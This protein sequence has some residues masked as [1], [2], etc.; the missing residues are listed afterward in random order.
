MEGRHLSQLLEDAAARRP[1]HPAV[2]DERGTRLNYAELLRGADRVATRL[3]RWGVGRGDRVGFWL[4]KGLEAVTAIHGI[5]RAGASYVPADPTGPPA[6]AAAILAAAGARAAIVSASMAQALRADWPSGSH[7]PRLIVVGDA[8]MPPGDADAP[9]ATWTEVM[10]DDAPSPLAPPRDDDD[11]AYILFTSGSTGQPKGVMLSHA[12]ALTFVDW[13]QQALGPW[14]VNDRFSSHAPLHFDLSIFDLFVA[15]HNAATL[16]LIGEV[17]GKDPGRLGD[18]LADRTISVWYSAPSILAMLLERG[19]LDRPGFA[20]PRVVLFAGEVFPMGSLRRLRSVWPH[21]RMWNLYG[22]T[23]TNVCTAL[24]VPEQ[25]PADRDAPLPIG[26]VCPPLR[27]RV[28]DHDGRDVSPGTLGELVIAG[29]GV[30]RG[31]FG[32][33]DLTEAAFLHDADGTPWYRTGDLV[34]D[35]GSGCFD[36]HGRRD[37]MIKRRGYRVELGEIESTLY[38]HEGVDRV[39]VVARSGEGGVS[40]EAFVAL[41]AGQKK[42][43][44]AMKR[45]CSVYLPNYMIPDTITFVDGLPATPTDKVDYQRL[46]A[47]AAG[48]G[49]R[50]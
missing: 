20:A 30:M 44:I 42:S 28:V 37:R 27:A 36:F 40:I 7:L 19:G 50:P 18:F 46:A 23:E 2:E 13:C 41:K 32:R 6:R 34:R 12:N 3:S 39:G 35:D 49:S 26:R 9:S 5:L 10:A 47:L 15:C 33:P 43:I 17:T 11:L 45:H 24:P 14:S 38:R 21:A 25:I 1:G 16:V 48:G 31:Y 8:A 4:P 29:P 22:P